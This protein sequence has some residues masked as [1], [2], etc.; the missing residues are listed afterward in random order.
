MNH[1]VLPLLLRISAAI[2]TIVAIA[3]FF[4]ELKAISAGNTPG[5]SALPRIL[6]MPVVTLAIALALA[7]LADLLGHVSHP[8]PEV[9]RSIGRLNQAMAD[10]QKRVDDVAVSA[11]RLSRNRSPAPA[12]LAPPAHV[13]ASL[14]PGALDPLLK[15][16]A[17]IRELA[18]LTDQE[19]KAR[20][21]TM[22]QE[23]K[24]MLV[25][26]VIEH[27]ERQRWA[28]GNATLETIDREN[29]NDAEAKRIRHQFEDARRNAESITVTRGR[30]QIE[31][32]MSIS[33]WDQ[34]F[35]AAK[36]LCD[37]FP[38][39][40]EATRMLARVQR[41]RDIHV[42]TSVARMVEEIR[43]DIDRR[44]WRRALMH[45]QRL[46][47]KFPDH[48]KTARINEQLHTLQENAEIE[49]RQELEVRIQELIRSHKFNEAIQLSE[50]LL[51]RFPHSP[52]AEAIESLL[53]RIRELA[54]EQEA[55]TA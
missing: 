10:L 43:H 24:R 41:E 12:P 53:P 51:G 44:L 42:E 23:R 46:V 17:E 11:D 29:P 4:F 33:A 34:A 38:G 35:T 28:E 50:E 54:K 3:I 16:I 5:I 32:F 13:T 2:I 36:R 31:N 6:G 40:V 18:L 39:N 25:R 48:P 14:A 27:I 8:A 15:A 21:V 20:L 47:E 19:R 26:Q 45:A 30:D 55:P 49:E 1:R 52:Q 9:M 22:E 37:D 7:G